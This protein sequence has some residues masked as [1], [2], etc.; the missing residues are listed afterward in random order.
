MAKIVHLEHG[1][2]VYVIDEIKQKLNGGT[3]RATGSIGH[4]DGD[5]YVPEIQNLTEYDAGS[6]MGAG[7]ALEARIKSI[8]DEKNAKVDQG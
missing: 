2:Y 6:P 8:I 3:W 4:F 7:F 1:G 5:E